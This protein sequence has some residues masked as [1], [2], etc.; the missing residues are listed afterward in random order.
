MVRKK[1]AVKAAPREPIKRAKKKRFLKPG[2]RISEKRKKEAE[3]ENKRP[4]PQ[5]PVAPI[6]VELPPR[7][8]DVIIDKAATTPKQTISL[9]MHE[10]LNPSSERKLAVV[11]VCKNAMNPD[12]MAEFK[13]DMRDLGVE[14]VFLVYGA[15]TSFVPTLEFFQR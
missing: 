1:Q 4:M 2:Q 13:K 3:A 10:L 8:A 6:T 9:S 5:D 15:N 11:K 7:I 12:G 14:V